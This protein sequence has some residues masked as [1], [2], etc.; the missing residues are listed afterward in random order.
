MIKYSFVQLG[1]QIST[2]WYFI[3]VLLSVCINPEINLGKYVWFDFEDEKTAFIK[4]KKSKCVCANRKTQIEQKCNK[5]ASNFVSKVVH[6][7]VNHTNL[8][9]SRQLI[10]RISSK[11]F[12]FGF[13][14][15]QPSY[16]FWLL[17]KNVSK[18]F[19]E[20]NQNK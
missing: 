13:K 12:N 15:C 20:T 11:F 18:M 19:F 3:K 7:T 6:S 1:G 17:P 14:S 2:D 10:E 5:K 9:I 16:L 8:K 4:E